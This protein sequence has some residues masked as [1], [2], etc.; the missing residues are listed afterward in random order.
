MECERRS[1]HQSSEE[2]EIIDV[3]TLDY[4]V[5]PSFTTDIT[6]ASKTI[7]N[8]PVSSTMTLSQITDKT[9]EM[10]TYILPTSTNN[11][12]ISHSS[13]M[14]YSDAS[15]SSITALSRSGYCALY[16]SPQSA[17]STI[18]SIATTPITHYW[19]GSNCLEQPSSCVINPPSYSTNIWNHVELSMND[20][21]YYGNAV[22]STAEE[23]NEFISIGCSY[24]KVEETIASDVVYRASAHDIRRCMRNLENNYGRYL[25]SCS[26]EQLHYILSCLIAKAIFSHLVDKRSKL[27]N[28]TDFSRELNLI[29]NKGL[30]ISYLTTSI[31]TTILKHVGTVA[32]DFF[33]KHI[34]LSNLTL[35]YTKNG[36]VG[37]LS[38]VVSKIINNKALVHIPK[39]EYEVYTVFSR[40]VGLLAPEVL[41]EFKLGQP[42]V[43]PR[44]PIYSTVFL[45]YSKQLE[46][47]LPVAVEHVRQTMFSKFGH[48]YLKLDVCNNLSYI[49]SRILGICKDFAALNE[50]N[51]ANGTWREKSTIESLAISFSR[52]ILLESKRG[53]SEVT[54]A[55][56]TIKMCETLVSEENLIITM[57]LIRSRGKSAV[58]RRAVN[59]IIVLF[60]RELR[61]TVEKYFKNY[62][63][64][65]INN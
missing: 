47:C 37:Y 53:T 2:D 34:K 39:I 31:M 38:Y 21:G 42:V 9:S 22:L 60:L 49:R 11:S 5:P 18:A 58:N 8:F 25:V 20:L 12:E 6:C 40:W 51:I 23:V 48:V 64:C 13:R 3:V 57:T 10:R 1:P 46:K 19:S 14:L 28:D 44:A 4:E 56:N 65:I 43:F 7:K 17:T 61:S 24:S 32:N 27:P 16:P 52:Y 59:Y 35:R 50:I 63:E 30:D 36:N 33:E 54:R 15:M 62:I 29:N 55:I 41:A 26:N 45:L